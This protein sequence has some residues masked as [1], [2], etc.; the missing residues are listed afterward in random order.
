M[1]EKE[2]KIGGGDGGDG[3][4]QIRRGKMENKS[5]KEGLYMTIWVSHQLY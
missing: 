4:D 3:T 5:A 2:S 1:G